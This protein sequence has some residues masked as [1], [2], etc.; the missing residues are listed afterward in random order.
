MYILIKK[1]RR[2]DVKIS[3]DKMVK[4][5]PCI[6]GN[7]YAIAMVLGRKEQG[8]KGRGRAGKGREGQGREGQGRGG[9]GREGQEMAVEGR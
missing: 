9:K 6:H 8:R 5:T 2:T 4:I 1:P 3:H 7:C